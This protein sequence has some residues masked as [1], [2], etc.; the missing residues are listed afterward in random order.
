MTD[1]ST[2]E[3]EVVVVGGGPGGL[4]SAL[5]TTRLN[6]DTALVDRGG[7]RAA[8]MLD[9]HNIIGVTE[10]TSGMEFLQTARDQLEGYGTT[11]YRNTVTGIERRGSPRRALS[12]RP[13][14]RVCGPTRLSS[15]RALTTRARSHRCRGPVGDCTGVSTVMRTCSAT[16]RCT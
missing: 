16:S 1:E 9:T 10:E 3:H 7:G 15:R 8:M 6:H 14:G 5:Y 13:T 2:A 12:S 11:L 4:T